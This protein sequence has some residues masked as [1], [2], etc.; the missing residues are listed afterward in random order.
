MAPLKTSI[1]LTGH[2]I[3][4]QLHK[5]QKFTLKSNM[6]FGSQF[7]DS[8]RHFLITFLLDFT[9][10]LSFSSSKPHLATRE[11]PDSRILC[12]DSSLDLHPSFSST[13]LLPDFYAATFFISIGSHA[14]HVTTACSS[15]SKAHLHFLNNFITIHCR[16]ELAR[17]C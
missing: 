7:S 4:L 16:N 15:A 1:I 14:S 8:S 2:S 17:S 12:T 3:K 10:F 13:T 6:C 5:G 9:S 11:D